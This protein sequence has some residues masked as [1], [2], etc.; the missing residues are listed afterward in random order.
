MWREKLNYTQRWVGAH[1]ADA[2]KMNIP[3]IVE[4]FG[5]A[6]PSGRINSAPGGGLQPG[7]SIHGGSGDYWVRDQFFESIYS[8]VEKSAKAGGSAR[9]TNFWVLY[10]NHG[11]G[12]HNDPYR[13]SFDDWS[14]MEKIR[15]H[16]RETRA[17]RSLSFFV[18][19]PRSFL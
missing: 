9:G 18:T 10:D 1:I 15:N 11:S 19:S 4:E 16:V 3:L 12:Q 17:S 6:I 5:K 2:D 14:T 8:Q 7:E 13:V